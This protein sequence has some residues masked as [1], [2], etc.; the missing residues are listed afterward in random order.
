VIEYGLPGEWRDVAVAG[1]GQESHPEVGLK[2]CQPALYGGL[3]AGFLQ[4]L[5]GWAAGLRGAGRF[6]ESRRLQACRHS[7][8]D[9]E[10][11]NV[12]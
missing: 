4:R 9:I 7:C 10:G 2:R 1:A 3:F 6:G 11:R 12:L 5:T 8:Q